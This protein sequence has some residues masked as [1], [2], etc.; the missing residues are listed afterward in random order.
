MARLNAGMEARAQQSAA[1][2][3]QLLLCFKKSEA[4]RKLTAFSFIEKQL[5]PLPHELGPADVCSF[6][7]PV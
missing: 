7:Q 6:G 4:K 2:N 1:A 3:S 5:K